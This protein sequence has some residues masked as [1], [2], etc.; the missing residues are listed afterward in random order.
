[1]NHVFKEGAS[2]HI[3]L[4]EGKDINGTVVYVA[5]EYV[6]LHEKRPDRKQPLDVYVNYSH[7]SHVYIG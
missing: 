7:I 3:Y 6:H 5:E 2:V 4:A 1:M